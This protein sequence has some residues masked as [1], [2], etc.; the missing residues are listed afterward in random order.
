MQKSI[1]S[2]TL[3]ALLL[4]AMLVCALC[5]TVMAEKVSYDFSG[6]GK[7][8]NIP[9]YNAETPENGGWII[10]PT[11][12]FTQGNHRLNWAEGAIG[13]EDSASRFG[14]VQDG[15]QIIYH[16]PEADQV[17]IKDYDGI[18]VNSRLSNA[19]PFAA[20]YGAEY[21]IILTMDDGQTITR[22]YKW[23]DGDITKVIGK[24]GLDVT[25]VD[26]AKDIAAL[27]GDP[28]LVSIAYVPYVDGGMFLLT[29]G[30]LYKPAVEDDPATEDVNESAPSVYGSAYYFLTSHFDLIEA[31]ELPTGLEGGLDTFDGVT[32]TEHNGKITGLSAEKTYKY[33]PVYSLDED[34][35]EV[36]GVTEITGLAGGVYEVRGVEADMLDSASVIVVVPK[37]AKGGLKFESGKWDTTG[38]N[39]DIPDIKTAMSSTPIYNT[40][41][42]TLKEPY[43]ESRTNLFHLASGY[44]PKCISGAGYVASSLPYAK[45]CRQN[46][47]MFTYVPSL[48]EQFDVDEFNIEATLRY[49]NSPVPN[50]V[51]TSECAIRVYTNGDESNPAVVTTP[52]KTTT[53]QV[54]YAS[55]RDQ[56]DGYVT[57]IDFINFYTLPENQTFQTISSYNMLTQVKTYAPSK[58]AAPSGLTI[59]ADSNGKG[60]IKGFDSTL[61]YA[62]STDNAVWTEVSGVTEIN[63]LEFT[64]YYVKQ[65]AS[66]YGDYDSDTVTVTIYGAAELVGEPKADGMNIVGLDAD[67]AY[68]WSTVSINGF[69]KW[70]DVPAGATK[71]ENLAN[72]L[73]AIRVKKGSDHLASKAAFVYLYD[74]KTNR[75][76]IVKVVDG[77]TTIDGT[78]A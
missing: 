42:A 20:S 19:N 78:A 15:T 65:L 68:E 49:Y 67:T 70:E 45:F 48:D 36:T 61:S 47:V 57:R 14:T 75:S 77:L 71:L 53:S 27:N 16:I 2:R 60:T 25:D 1:A 18:V 50:I 63:G 31:S 59:D 64:T 74:Y 37:T 52:Y 23:F 66:N 7:T 44:D 21:A 26:I 51:D 10:V 3:T 72:G 5:V 56:L 34:F 40:W 54:A 30:S 11:K 55:V 43:P 58:T 62:Y 6:Y 13:M 39:A 24:G 28:K 69:D 4:V 12:P 38:T 46:V 41:T 33:A 35:V 73:Y 9:L 32:V 76:D 8:A 22:E 29:P 17:N